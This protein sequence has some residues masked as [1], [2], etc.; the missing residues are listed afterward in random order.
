MIKLVVFDFDGTLLP[1]GEKS[2][3][4]TIVSKIIGYIEKGVTFAVASGRTY[5]ELKALLVPLSDYIY[6]IADDGALTVKNDKIIYKKPFSFASLKA[7][8]DKESFT[9]ATFYSFD[10]AFATNLQ[11][12]QNYGKRIKQARRQFD[13]NEDIYKISA[14]VTKAPP[15]N[16]ADYRVHFYENDFAEFVTPYSNKGVALANLQLRLTV[17]RYET[18]AIGDAAND[19]PMMM[20]SNYSVSVGDKCS[21]LIAKTKFRFPSIEKAFDLLSEN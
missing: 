1:Y 10:T 6:F 9:D 17:S 15:Q 7:F 5:A 21:E 4:D 8:F 16:T 2:V 18:M 13:I 3:S 11:N 20:H 19:I 12:A 14:N